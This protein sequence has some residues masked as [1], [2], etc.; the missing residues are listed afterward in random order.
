MRPIRLLHSGNVGD[1][2]YSLPLA[3]SFGKVEYYL[4]I[5]HLMNEKLAKSILPLLEKQP[6]IEKVKL[7]N[8]KTDKYDWNLD[9]FRQIHAMDIVQL[10]LAHLIKFNCYYNLAEPYIHNIEP[11]YVADIIINRTMRYWGDLDY[12]NYWEILEK[13]GDRAIFIGYEKEYELFRSKFDRKKK[14]EYYKTEDFLE[15]AQIIKG[16]KVFIG[17]QSCCFAI[18]EAMKT[19]R[20]L[21]ICREVP[22][23]IPIGGIAYTS[24]E[25]DL[26]EKLD[27]LLNETS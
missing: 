5:S 26:M 18:A 12:L 1:I 3:K 10:T 15:V 24:W 2:V 6:Y 21:E 25:R 17:N 16:S 7:Y 4:N 14:L 8:A 19:P 22:N 27:K 9:I 11:N 20:I 23:C 13:Y